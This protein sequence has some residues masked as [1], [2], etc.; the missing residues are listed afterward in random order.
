MKWIH[1]VAGLLSLLAGFTALYAAKG[2]DWHRRAGTLFFGAML[3][4]ASSGALMAVFIRPNPVNVM[5]G[6][7]TSYLVLTG[8][9]AVKRPVVEVRGW[10]VLLMLAALALA[11]FAWSLV[12][13]A[14]RDPRGLVGGVPWPPLALFGTVGLAGAL[15]DARLLLAGTLRGGHRL[16]RHLWRLGFALWIAT[17]SFFL[18]QPRVFPDFLRQNIGLRTIPVLVVAL[19]V[20]YWLVRVLRKRRAAAPA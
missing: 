9:L 1:I 14:L 16:A 3:V 18:G 8:W 6:S 17:M 4:M 7:M 2:G 5:A 12:A 11:G 13:E 19:V 20:G 10:L 15:L